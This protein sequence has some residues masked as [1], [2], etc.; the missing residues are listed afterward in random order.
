MLRRSRWILL[1]ILL[2]LFSLQLQRQPATLAQDIIPPNAFLLR[3]KGDRPITFSL[4]RGNGP[5]TQYQLASGER[6]LYYDQN[7]IWLATQGQEPVHYIL[8]LGQRYRIIWLS[9]RWDITRMEL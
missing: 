6:A 1:L 5:W 7:E 4:R 9:M 3:N 2:G 8:E